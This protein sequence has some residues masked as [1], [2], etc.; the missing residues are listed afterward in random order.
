MQNIELIKGDCLEKMKDIPDESIDMILCDLPYGTTQCKWDTI[1]PFESLW[2]QYNRVIKKNGA[3]VLFGSEPFTSKL[4]NSN[5]KG[6]REKI[7]WIKHKPSN[8]ACANY[9]HMKYCEDIIVF[10][11]KKPTFNKIMQI[12]NSDRVRQMQNG[13]SKKW[14]TVRNDGNEVSMQTQYEPKDWNDYNANL[15]NPMDYIIYPTVVSNSK[16]KVNHPTQKPVDL[17][18]Y[19]IKT[20]SDEGETVLDNTMGSGSTGVACINI[21]R[22]FIGIELDNN[23]FNISVNRV[24]TYIKDNKLEQINLEINS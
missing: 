17:L 20:Y 15:K 18:E 2:K 14:N 23:Y 8:F 21:N 12:R 5:L 19:L 1:I 4:I 22:N 3:I 9:M 10:G 11:Y 13:K 6:Y 7:T 24:N 16:E